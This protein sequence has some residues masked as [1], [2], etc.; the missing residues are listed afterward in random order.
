MSLQHIMTNSLSFTYLYNGLFSLDL[1]NLSFSHNSISQS[2]ID[3]LGV[4][5]ELDVLEDD[6]GSIDIEDSSVV[7]S[8][9]NVV[10]SGRGQEVCLGHFIL[11][12]FREIFR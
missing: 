1:Q 12:G 10:V 2:D 9:S 5:G 4:L 8:R 11:C 6:E 3:N 7:D